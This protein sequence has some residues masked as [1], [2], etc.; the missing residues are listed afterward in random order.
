[1]E[2]QEL[3][4]APPHFALLGQALLEHRVVPLLRSSL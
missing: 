4:K 3:L 2:K 1:M